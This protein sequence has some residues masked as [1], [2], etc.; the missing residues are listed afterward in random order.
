MLQSFIDTSRISLVREM[1]YNVELPTISL[2]R[3]MKMQN[4][5]EQQSNNQV[6]TGAIHKLFGMLR[7]C[8][9]SKKTQQPTGFLSISLKLDVTCSMDDYD[10]HSRNTRTSNP[11]WKHR[12]SA[13]YI[14]F[15]PETF[16]LPRVD[17]IVRFETGGGRH[18][19]PSTYSVLC[20]AL[21]R[22]QTTCWD[23]TL[24]E[25]RLPELRRKIRSA[26]VLALNTVQLPAIVKFELNSN[27]YSPLN[28]RLEIEAFVEPGEPDP[29]SPA[30]R[31]IAVLPTLREFH[32]SVT[33]LSPD[34][35]DFDFKSSD[36]L[37]NIVTLKLLLCSTTADGR[38]YFTG[39]SS[40][41][42][43]RLERA[44]TPTEDEETP[45]AFD[46]DDSDTS[47]YEPP[48]AW[49]RLNGE[50]PNDV[51]RNKGDPDTLSPFLIKLCDAVDNMPRLQQAEIC[52]LSPN[53]T[54]EYLRASEGAVQ[55]QQH[56]GR[57][58]ITG[59]NGRDINK[60]WR[61]P[62][63]VENALK[64]KDSANTVQLDRIE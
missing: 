4:R 58:H 2:K 29:M 56:V 47:D 22:L 45:A 62:V 14:A 43:D 34:I 7:Q 15:D 40:V 1:I 48:F 8:Q 20:S 9:N 5:R 49:R 10:D 19:H 26:T 50:V 61:F 17:C 36:S 27:E 24:P 37:P 35:F 25:R 46:S 12:N 64:G 44:Y 16:T 13:S 38:W 55:Q 57:W 52:L 54:M 51:F 59:M 53:M 6:F 23:T 63:D 21:P 42:D 32:V 18:F 33:P 31:R 30:L 39:S 60:E 28:E 41:A 11:I 3:I